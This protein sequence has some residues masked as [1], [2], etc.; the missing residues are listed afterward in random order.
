MTGS[1]M[2]S[3]SDWP[4]AGPSPAARRGWSRRLKASGLHL[5]ASLV[6]AGLVAALVFGLWYP[7]P[8]GEIAGGLG[9][10]TILVSVDVV[11]GPMLTAVIAAPAKSLRELRRDLAVI[12]LVQLAGLGYGL[13]SMAQARPVHLAFEIDR[14][15]VIAATDIDEGL[16]PEAPP[17]LRTLPW[18]GPTT[19]AAVKPTD[20]NEQLKSIDLALAGFDL[21]YVPRNWRPY[22]SE[23]AMAWSRARPAAQLLAHSPGQVDAVKR[24]AQVAGVDAAALRFLPVVSR[25]ASWTVL[26][27]PPDARPVGYLPV[28]AF[29]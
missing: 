25:R 28:D 26:L 1:T 22:R 29:F 24:M 12:V 8:Y 17:E 5:L 27:A 23:S 15:R 14:F 9:L 4:L 2:T 18:F 20:P 7:Y 11:L 19:I 16:L 13:F 21:S 6:V 10:F 3:P